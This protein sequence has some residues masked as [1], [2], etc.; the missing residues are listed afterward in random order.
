MAGQRTSSARS[1]RLYVYFDLGNPNSR[2]VSYTRGVLLGAVVI[3]AAAPACLGLLSAAGRSLHSHPLPAYLVVLQNPARLMPFF[4]VKLS[5]LVEQN[6]LAAVMLVVTSTSWIKDVLLLPGRLVKIAAQPCRPAC[7]TGAA[8]SR[9][10]RLG[11]PP[12]FYVLLP[13]PSVGVQQ[14]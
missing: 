5:V 13:G 1:N 9:L 8:K 3:L 7:W 14:L 10:R 12:G 11:R 2:S 6:V 4:V